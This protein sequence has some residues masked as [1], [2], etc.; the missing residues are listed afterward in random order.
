MTAKRSSWKMER[1]SVHLAGAKR[2]KSNKYTKNDADERPAAHTRKR[3]WIGAYT[4][5]DG[6]RVEG[7]Y[8]KVNHNISQS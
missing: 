6:H 8:R 5:A 1:A 7:H 2:A 4:R 3:V